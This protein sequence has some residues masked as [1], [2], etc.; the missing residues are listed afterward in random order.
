MR[1]VSIPCL[2]YN[3]YFALL[4]ERCRIPNLILAPGKHCGELYE[5]QTILR[6]LL[7]S[8][9]VE[10]HDSCCMIVMSQERWVSTYSTK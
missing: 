7:N 8:T 9:Y 3:Q 1:F 2:S 10:A 4:S 5:T 6:K